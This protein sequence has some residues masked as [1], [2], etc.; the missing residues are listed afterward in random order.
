MVEFR[1]LGPLEVVDGDRRVHIR[2][3]TQGAL[4]AVLLL[5]ANE[6]VPRDVLVDELWGDAPPPTATKIVQNSISRLRK[7]LP[8]GDSNL[9]TGDHSYALRVEES[10]IDGIRFE[11]AVEQGRAA[12]GAG[13][14]SRAAEV[15]RM[16]L[17]L[18]R[19]PALADFAYEEF[20]QREIARLEELHLVAVLERI[21]ADLALG[22]HEQV[23]GELEALAGEHPFNERIRAQLMLS[24]YRAGRQV[25]ALEVYRVTRETLVDE[26]GVEPSEDLRHLEQAI[27]RHDPELGGPSRSWPPSLPLTTSR[28]AKAALALLT[29]IFIA[30]IVTA[31]V[32]LAFGSDSHAVRLTSDSIAVVDGSTGRLTSSIP[33]GGEQPVALALGDGSLWAANLYSRTVSRLDPQ[34]GKLVTS[35][36]TPGPPTALAA[37]DDAVWVADEF[38]GA[39]LRIEPRSGSIVD[40]LVVGGGPSAIA[41]TPGYVWVTDRVDGQV[42]RIDAEDDA[43]VGRI[44]VGSSP[45]GIVSGAGAIWVA[46]E[47]DRTVTRIATA[48]GMVTRA[49]IPLGFAPAGLAYGAGAL[50]VSGPESHV[51]ARIDPRSNAVS[52]I[53][54]A[55]NDPTGLAVAGGTIWIADT[56]GRRLTAIDGQSGKVRRTLPLELTPDAM[57]ASQGSVWVTVHRL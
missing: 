20:A 45:S 3:G 7:T 36:G 1:V 4:L 10:Q 37:G 51:V 32:F 18:W 6:F 52:R 27:L 9:V 43:V 12:L 41:L 48:S 16:A 33:S 47:L 5:H 35:I 17:L 31:L 22:R 56:L 40:S 57:V 14:P 39:V 19:G 30:L 2:T 13:D 54:V 42:L 15:L 44:R 8:G 11:R 34:S 23:I 26:L 46:N 55:G 28:R 50:W 29:S 53:I 24:L 49:R 38:Q 25:E 21:E